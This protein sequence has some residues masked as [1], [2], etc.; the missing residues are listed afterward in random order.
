MQLVLSLMLI[1]EDLGLYGDEVSPSTF[2]LPT[3]G[4]RL[5]RIAVDIHRGKGFA[6][7]R[8]LN[9][10][11]LSPEDNV[12]A[13]LGISGYIGATRGRQDEEGNMLSKPQF[14]T[15]MWHTAI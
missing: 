10:D 6:V 7:I 1:R 8:G 11:E 2:P 4:P 15:L 12:L 13:F 9:P 3:L 14:L 5:Q